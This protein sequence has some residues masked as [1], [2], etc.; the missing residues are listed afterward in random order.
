M[1]TIL[2]VILVS[3]AVLLVTLIMI[4]NRGSSLGAAFGGDT[5][6][7]YQRR[8]GE[9]MLHYLTILL[10]VIFVGTAFASLFVSK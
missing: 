2:Q 10:A 1:K 6:V 8:G 7:N 3:D 9:K 5:S 4:Q